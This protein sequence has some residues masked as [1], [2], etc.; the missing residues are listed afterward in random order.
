MEG[1]LRVKT[2]SSNWMGD[3]DIITRNSLNIQKGIGLRYCA[4]SL[5]VTRD[6]LINKR[7][8]QFM[9]PSRCPQRRV[10]LIL[11][12]YG[13]TAAVARGLSG[14]TISRA[15]LGPHAK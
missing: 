9:D 2:T 10:R 14:L 5:E 6:V 3:C 15:A 1:D 7:P 12:I 8:V 11:L 13:P 4:P